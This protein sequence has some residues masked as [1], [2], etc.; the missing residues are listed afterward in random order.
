MAAVGDRATVA[1]QRVSAEIGVDLSG[2]RAHPLP[3]DLARRADLVLV[4]TE[5]QRRTVLA[6]QPSLAR[7]VELLDP[8]GREIPDPYGRSDDVYRATRERIAEAISVRAA[9]W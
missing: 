6:E 9:E 5:Q 8:S 4:M 2:H 3:P 1:A 7:R